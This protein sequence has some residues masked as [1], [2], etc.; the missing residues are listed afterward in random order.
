MHPKDVL[1]IV[2]AVLLLALSWAMQEPRTGTQI[3]GARTDD[4][5][6]RTASTP[7]CAARGAAVA[8]LRASGHFTS[9]QPGG[10]DATG[11][12]TALH[13]YFSDCP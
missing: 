2:L 11:L 1:P 13:E 5:R 7:Q 8:A 4:S 9:S 6:V 10:V 3:A 12:V